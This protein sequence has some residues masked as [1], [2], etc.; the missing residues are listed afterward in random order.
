MQ[1]IRQDETTVPMTM[2]LEHQVRS[3]SFRRDNRVTRFDQ[4]SQLTPAGL[5]DD[6]LEHAIHFVSDPKNFKRKG[7][8]QSLEGRENL[9]NLLQ[10]V[11]NF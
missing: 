7:T 5:T 1:L 10:I 2:T 6:V 11:W 9:A 3:V 8:L 4:A